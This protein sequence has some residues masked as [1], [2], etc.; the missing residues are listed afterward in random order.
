VFKTNIAG[1]D[2]PDLHEGWKAMILGNVEM[3]AIDGRHFEVVNEPFVRKLAAG[4]TE[5]L[6][7][8]QSRNPV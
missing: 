2:N 5:C 6:R 4:L 8:K 7:E 3:R 1:W